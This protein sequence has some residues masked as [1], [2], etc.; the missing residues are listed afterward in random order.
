MHCDDRN[1]TRLVSVRV[2]T[3][4]AP[5]AAAVKAFALVMAL[6]VTP[7]ANFLL[8]EALTVCG[9]TRD[10]RSDAVDKGTL[11]LPWIFMNHLVLKRGFC[12]PDRGNGDQ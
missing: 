7:Q 3:Y 12:L 10:A 8:S 2:H 4:S 9:E 1:G 11:D 6:P 5:Y